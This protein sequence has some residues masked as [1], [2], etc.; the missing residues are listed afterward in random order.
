M[1]STKHKTVK[2]NAKLSLDNSISLLWFRGYQTCRVYLFCSL[3]QVD[4]L[5]H[6]I[7]TQVTNLQLMFMKLFFEIAV[8]SHA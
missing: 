7:T 4:K 5:L 2:C 1:I 3:Q 8:T 6:C